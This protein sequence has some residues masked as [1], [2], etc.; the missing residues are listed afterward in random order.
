[1]QYLIGNKDFYKV[2]KGKRKVEIQAYN[3]TPSNT[4]HCKNETSEADFG[5]FEKIR[6]CLSGN[7]QQ[8]TLYF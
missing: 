5:Y 2:I 8:S 1:M 3:F 7:N 4:Y 6:H